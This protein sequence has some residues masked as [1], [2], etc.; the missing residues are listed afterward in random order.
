MRAWQGDSHLS[1]HGGSSVARHAC[2]RRGSCPLERV[3][4]WVLCVFT[5]GLSPDRHMMVEEDA[6]GGR[7]E[8]NDVAP[9]VLQGPELSAG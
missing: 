8:H 9:T 5:R 1:S 7:E 3:L 6:I 4:D 2:T